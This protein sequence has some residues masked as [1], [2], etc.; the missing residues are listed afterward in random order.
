MLQ[1]LTVIHWNMPCLCL[2]NES[3][4]QELT[5]AIKNLINP[6]GSRRVP[7]FLVFL[8]TNLLMI[9]AQVRLREFIQMRPT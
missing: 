9:P 1:F 4:D 2:E 3:K 6:E 7:I 8:S 5:E